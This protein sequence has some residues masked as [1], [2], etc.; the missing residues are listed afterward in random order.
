MLRADRKDKTRIGIIMPV[1]VLMRSD[2]LITN[3]AVGDE[4]SGV[5]GVILK[6]F[7]QAINVLLDKAGVIYILR[8]PGGLK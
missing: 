7:A 5:S 3:G 8:P 4:H 1:T 6:F 2:K